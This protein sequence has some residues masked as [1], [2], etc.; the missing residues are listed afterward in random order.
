[1]KILLRFVS[2][3]FF[4][5]VFAPSIVWAKPVSGSHLKVFI[6]S[7]PYIYISHS[8]NAALLRPANNEQGWEYDMATSHKVI[9]ERTYE[10]T[11]RKGVKFQDGT[12]F[13]ADAVLLNMEHFK[14]AP[15]LFT[16]IDTVFD[17]AEK[18][19]DYTVR[20]HLTQKYG[21]FLNDAIW[22]QFYTRTYLEK[23]GWNGKATCPNL[24]EPGPY[25]LGPYI[26]K[27]GYIE[28]DRQT[29][30]AVLEA[31][32][33]YWNPEYPKIEKVTVYTELDS[34]VALERA[35]D[36]D[37][38]LDIMPIPVSEKPRVNESLYAKL[39]TA[40]STDNIAIHINM[41]T[42]NKRLQDK[43]VRVA[44]NKA[45]DQRRLLSKY[46]DGEGQI[47]P[48]LAAPLYPGVDKV[49]KKL[50]AY[51]E[52]EDP[53]AIRDQLKRTLDGLVLN[54]YTQDRYMHIWKGID[55][56]LRKV[57]VKLK[58][59]ITTSEKDVFG[60]LL[61]TNAG[62]NTKKW[63]LLA[64]GDDDWYYNHP[65]SAFLV[66]RTH[67]YWSTISPDPQLNNYVEE[68]FRESVGS[69][70]FDNVSEKI[71]YH[72]YDNGYMLFVPTPNKV[73]AVN[74]QVT[75]S[76]YRMANMPLWEIEVSDDHWSVR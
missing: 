67:N 37:G 2:A 32:P 41:I 40:P 22:I 52:V 63:D 62:K 46:Y 27:E 50:K 59:D 39:V 45:I 24:A 55:R 61:S 9:D 31:N 76:P 53:K 73:L 49:V 12:P 57:G 71:M 58:F 66:Y 18:I 29:P 28:G 69:P 64:W 5:F 65:W 47:K 54:V 43:A 8:I 51:S 13:N 25:G 20:F 34:K 23:F 60:Q 15:F 11:L 21:Q 36:R 44:L 6:P 38:E 16:K 30:N 68:M 74:K 72:V 33:N 26:L 10:F 48:T 17:R 70:A 7:L 75:Y 14:K 19:D 4:L 56:D 42:G 1:M 35:I 3:I